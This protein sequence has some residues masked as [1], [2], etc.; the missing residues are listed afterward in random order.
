[1]L[2]SSC[3]VANVSGFQQRVAS[4]SLSTTDPN[5]R[6]CVFDPGYQIVHF[7]M[8]HAPPQNTNVPTEL[9]ETV[10]KSQ[11]QLLHTLLDYNRSYRP[12]AVFE[13]SIIE[14]SYDEQYIQQL[15]QGLRERDSFTR[16]DG[17]KF[18]IANERRRALNL[19][20]VFPAFYEQMN[21]LQKQFLYDLG[22]SK[23]LYLLGE[24][25]RLYAVITPSEINL[26]RGQLGNNFNPENLRANR[27]WI[28]DFRE[29]VL[30][31]RILDFRNQNPSWNGLV[32]IPYGA[33][34][35]FLDDFAGLPFQ[36]G[37]F[38]LKWNNTIRVTNSSSFS[39]ASLIF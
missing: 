4:R 8:W 3:N 22:A 9:F 23:I 5:L 19:F 18:F 2:L 20:P 6:T 25:P 13:E 28:Y 15:A 16:L 39:K 26:V 14:D 7:P 12:I 37:S 32:F 31:N 36:S 1:L 34:H 33:S 30:R 21:L 10:A 29:Q 11:F 38:C 35:D 24:L 27:Y 17:T